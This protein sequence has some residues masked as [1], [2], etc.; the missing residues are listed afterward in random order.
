MIETAGDDLFGSEDLLTDAE[1]STRDRVAEYA[2][3]E[4]APGASDRWLEGRFDTGV[5]AGLAALGVIGGG[6]E[7]YGCSGDGEVTEGLVAAELAATDMGV[8]AFFG[9]Q[10][11]LSMR[12]I[13][14]LGSPEQ[15]ERWL[16]RMARLEHIGAFG[17][18]EPDH[19][20]DISGMET[21]A[22]RTSSGYILNGRKRWVGNAAMADVVV[23]FARGDD[24]TPGAYVV[25]KGAPGFHAAPI[26]GKV[27]F[28]SAHPTDITLD[29][30]HIAAENRLAGST[31]P[32]QAAVVLNGI[33]PIAA[34]QALGLSVG[35]YRAVVAYVSR[36]EQFGKPLAAFQ[37]VQE[38]LASMAVAISSMRLTA[39]RVSRLLESGRMTQAHAAAAKLENTRRGRAIVSAARDLMGGNGL[40]AEHTVGRHF[41]DMEAVYTYDGTDHM[42]A[43]M[44]GR[45][46]TGIS[47]LR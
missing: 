17:I 33:R 21:T 1:R 18:T 8:S 27:A 9:I 25:E 28:R 32:K 6:I 19:G 38:K 34:W 24:G 46:I 44:I 37:L 30:V 45:F 16:P 23:I 31:D 12:A 35:A 2:A 11:S 15:R 39:V 41:A 36:R 7:G 43:L 10:S 42:Q 29:D 4:L 47:A 5:L 3:S 14:G 22:R 26:E 13:A 40:L 20:S